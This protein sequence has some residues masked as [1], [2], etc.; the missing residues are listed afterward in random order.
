VVRFFVD[1]KSQNHIIMLPD[2]EISAFPFLTP[3]FNRIVLTFS[4]KGGSRMN[5]SRMASG[6]T[7]FLFGL[8]LCFGVAGKPAGA[9]AAGGQ[10]ETFPCVA[11]GETV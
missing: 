7:V 11:E 3:F 2:R 6:V 1:T 10:P 8:L 9:P 4:A 5:P